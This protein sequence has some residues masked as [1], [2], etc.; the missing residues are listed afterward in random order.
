M[1]HSPKV[2]G[3]FL[4]PLENIKLFKMLKTGSA[5]FYFDRLQGF[6]AGGG[7]LTQVE[8]RT[9]ALSSCQGKVLTGDMVS[10]A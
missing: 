2:Y 6:R 9:K 7:S 4:D 10:K 5:I 3:I 1:I 8:A